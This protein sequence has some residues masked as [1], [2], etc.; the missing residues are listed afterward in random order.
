MECPQCGAKFA[1]SRLICPE[2]HAEITSLVSEVFPSLE[3]TPPREKIA[4]SVIIPAYNAAHTI[5]D[6]L[7]SL[8]AQECSERHEVIVADSSNDGTEAIIT[9]EFPKVKLLHRPQQTDPGTARNL[10]QGQIIACLDA[11]CIAAPDWL[12]RILESQRAGHRVVGGSVVNGNP[13]SRLAWAGYMGEFREFI[14]AGKPRIVPHIPTCN[15]AYHRS[16]FEEFGGFPTRFYPQEDLLY[17]WRLSQHGVALWFD[18]QLTV[19]H[20]HRSTWGQYL[21]HQ[22]RIGQIT[23]RVLQV[24]DGEGAFLARSRALALL[25]APF[26]PLFKWS[27]TLGVFLNHDPKTLTG[28]PIAAMALLAGLYVWGIGFVAGAWGP[29]LHW[30]DGEGLT[31]QTA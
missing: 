10:A 31:W 1:R 25:A 11:D 8:E 5:C 17:H 12:A 9:R 21:R 22:R 19:R 23:A 28:H 7:R 24:T 26:L 15:I 14:P 27:R 30:V 16:I 29:P 18:P 2:C 13:D 3:A 4:I 20:V 6:T